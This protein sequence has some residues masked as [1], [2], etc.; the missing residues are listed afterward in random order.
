MQQCS[1]QSMCGQRLN[2]SNNMKA[3]LSLIT[4][5][6]L[7]ACTLAGIAQNN[8]AD[9]SATTSTPASISDGSAQPADTQTSAATTD[10]ATATTQPAAASESAPAATAPAV[11]AAT[12][13]SSAP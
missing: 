7:M 2:Q 3:K 12:D 9:Q 10:A 5:L 11:I 4:V 8:P 1:C 6:G 13:A